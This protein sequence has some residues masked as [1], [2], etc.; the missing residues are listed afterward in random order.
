MR[1]YV[2][3]GY[4]N[5][6]LRNV[7]PKTCLPKRVPPEDTG[8]TLDYLLEH[9]SDKVEVAKEQCEPERY[10]VWLWYAFDG[11]DKA[12]TPHREFIP[13]EEHLAQEQ[14]RLLAPPPTPEHEAKQP[15]AHE[16]D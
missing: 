6:L 5:G 2:L 7:D 9:Y 15:H 16:V 8:Q 13:L 3:S 12:S 1:Q 10:D 14:A 11:Y 4:L